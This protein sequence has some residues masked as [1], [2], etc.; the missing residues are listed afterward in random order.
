MDGEDGGH[1]VR[2]EQRR[3]G[4]GGAA[5]AAAFT[6][7]GSCR[8]TGQSRSRRG[9][10]GCGTEGGACPGCR[11]SASRGGGTLLLRRVPFPTAPLLLSTRTKRIP[12]LLEER[13]S[14]ER[15]MRNRPSLTKFRRTE[16]APGLGY[17]PP[18]AQTIIMVVLGAGGGPFQEKNGLWVLFFVFCLPPPGVVFWFQETET[19][20]RPKA[21]EV[22]GITP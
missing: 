18:L 15:W 11:L 5:A 10:K 17:M 21:V 8:K 20:T 22:S 4:R 6:F 9:G 19:P 2:G 12:C 7:Y 13:A 1:R 3:V 16:A 14:F